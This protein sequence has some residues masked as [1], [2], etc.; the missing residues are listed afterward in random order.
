MKISIK[1]NIGIEFIVSVL[2][3]T[4]QIR[5][6]GPLVSY[7]YHPET[8]LI[9]AQCYV[10]MEGGTQHQIPFL[11]VISEN[12]QRA[13]LGTQN[14]QKDIDI[15]GQ[16]VF[17]GSGII[18]DEKR[19][20]Y[21]GRKEDYTIGEIDV[22]Q[23]M[24]LFSIQCPDSLE[25]QYED[26]ISLENRIKEAEKRGAAAVVLFSRKHDYPFLYARYDHEGNIPQIPVITISKSSFIQIMASAGQNGKSILEEWKKKEKPPQSK[27]LISK[28]ALKIEGSFDQVENDHF[29]FCFR[30]NTIPKKQ[31]NKLVEINEKA[32]QFIFN[33]F[34]SMEKPQ[35]QKKMNVYFRDYD[36]KLFYTHH[37]GRGLASSEGIFMVHQ[38][39]IPDFGLAVHENTHLYTDENWGNET[40][41]F[42]SEGIAKYLQALAEDKDENHLA[43][44]KFL[45]NQELFPLEE[46][47]IHQIGMSG[48][49]TTVG[50]PAAGSFTGFLVHSYGKDKFKKAY[51]LEGRPRAEKEK[52]DTWKEVYEKDIQTLESL[53]LEWVVNEYQ[54]EKNLLEKHFDRIAA[55]RQ[56]KKEREALKPKRRDFP[57]YEGTYIWREM[58]KEFSI[59]IEQDALFMKIHG[60]PGT[61]ARLI[62]VEKHEFR[63]EGGPTNGQTMIFH[64]DEKGEV[65][66]A[67]MGDFEFMRQ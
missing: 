14:Y 11:P 61:T 67:T 7:Y 2:M 49:K 66:K 47:L 20:D 50:Y 12:L 64:M 39:E 29:L 9:F 10:Y 53:W 33:Y 35:W 57:L 31:M 32:I 56:K 26:K 44:I 38:G 37:W 22:S 3:L 27:A 15:Q 59:E 13:P 16:L 5:A 58:D 18:L 51:I 28:L 42:M 23:K 24:V 21:K 45:K 8:K 6:Q 19:N 52:K 34:K 63:L 25:K 48:P 40:S 65:I 43:V 41:S 54:I 62:P 46:L 4:A 60:M 36:S 17:I 1:K 55:I 30:E